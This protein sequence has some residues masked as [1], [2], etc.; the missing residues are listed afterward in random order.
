MKNPQAL[1]MNCPSCGASMPNT[2]GADAVTCPY[3]GN[4]VFFDKDG[5][6]VPDRFQK[7]ADSPAVPGTAPAPARPMTEVDRARQEYVRQELERRRKNALRIP[8]FAVFFSLALGGFIAFISVKEQQKQQ[9][10]AQE[11]TRQAQE[12]VRRNIED[13]TKQINPNRELWS[14]LVDAHAS[15]LPVGFDDALSKA[16][17]EGWPML[18]LGASNGPVKVTWYVTY[19]GL[20]EKMVLG[21]IRNALR[22]YKDRVRVN[23]IPLP[24]QDVR[25]ADL[26]EALVEIVQQKGDAVFADLH[27]RLVTQGVP[28]RPV[29]LC[30]MMDC[31]KAAFN[32]AMKQ[33]AHAASVR[34]LQPVAKK[35]GLDRQTVV[36]IQDSLF[37]DAT[38]VYAQM[39]LAI[40]GYLDF[41]EEKP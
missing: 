23:V 4:T 28:R 18:T 16:M 6:G 1:Q 3:C 10:R 32:K 24:T 26:L 12:Q 27:E 13:A 33:H 7:K 31:D 29:D 38:S 37:V 2:P 20:Y 19:A 40:Q 35:L 36:R 22:K 17:P 25:N 14:R 11:I 15:R 30:E 39:E 41:P 9:R 5:D 21:G 8:L 34:G